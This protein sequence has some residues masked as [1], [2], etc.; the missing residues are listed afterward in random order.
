V[1]FFLNLSPIS[2]SPHGIP[3]ATHQ[4]LF[5]VPSGTGWGDLFDAHFLSR[6][7]FNRALAWRCVDD[8]TGIYEGRYEH[9]QISIFVRSL[10]ELGAPSKI[11]KAA[12]HCLQSLL[13]LSS[14]QI[15]GAS[16]QVLTHAIS[17]VSKYLNFE[18][19]FDRGGISSQRGGTR[20]ASAQGV[21]CGAAFFAAWA[22]P[23]VCQ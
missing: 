3:C 2:P 15:L 16:L 17:W 6:M 14:Y 8:G 22:S 10:G 7:V 9:G 5:V 23:V 13:H 11:I 12:G 19:D 4:A 20:G 21:P 18:S 1:I